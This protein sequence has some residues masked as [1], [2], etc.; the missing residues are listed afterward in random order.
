MNN[1]KIR[2]LYDE[3]KFN[4]IHSKTEHGSIQ[5]KKFSHPLQDKSETKSPDPPSGF[6][7]ITNIRLNSNTIQSIA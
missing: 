3:E 7:S 1:N 4:I 5:F 2:M 6:L